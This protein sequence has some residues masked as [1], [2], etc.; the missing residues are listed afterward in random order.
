M[1]RASRARAVPIAIGVSLCVLARTAVADEG[2]GQA[3][4]AP[5]GLASSP[6]E[7]PRSLAEI[8]ASQQSSKATIRAGFDGT[9]ASSNSLAKMHL[10][11][12]NWSVTGSAPIG[13]GS[14]PT[15]V[16]TLDGLSDA[17]QLAAKAQWVY[18]AY[19]S[20]TESERKPL[21]EQIDKAVGLVNEDLLK[22][23]PVDRE[24]KLEKLKKRGCKID[25]EKVA[26]GYS[27]NMA[28]CLL[29]KS[30]ANRYRRLFFP[31]KS[32]LIIP[33]LSATA[34]SKNY[35][36]LDVALDKNVSSTRTPWSVQAFL[37][38][39]TRDSL[40]TIGYRYDKSYKDADQGSL[41]PVA[42]GS[43][44]QCKAGPLGPPSNKAQSVPFVEY[45]HRV[46]SNFAV[47]PIANYDTRKSV[48]G[49]SLPLYFV[50]DATGNLSG[51]IAV[52]WRN[53]Q[54]GLQV[55]VVV[56]TAFSSFPGG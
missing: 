43:M 22:S 28:D 19:L 56:S 35:K 51:G 36:Y 33:G 54:G 11:S 3:I 47:A 17:A 34:A 4:T 41:C 40:V 10:L 53:D 42:T 20:P 44:T 7:T 27:T 32:M 46:S 13:T 30:D 9:V 5:N 31:E 8:T 55:S 1:H 14:D 37:G 29:S 18:G 45:R 25:K 26:V 50:P 15:Q 6:V 49:I 16:A 21:K 39:H 52:G 38:F 48:L 23:T 2:T 12:W 24:Q